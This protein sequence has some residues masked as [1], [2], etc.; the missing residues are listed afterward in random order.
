[1]IR[2]FSIWK[3]N[4]KPLLMDIRDMEDSPSILG[5]YLGVERLADAGFRQLGRIAVL[6]NQER[7]DADD[8]FETTALNRGLQFRFFYADEKEAIAWLTHQKGN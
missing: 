3:Q 4:Q 7:H 6:D 2:V 5:D 1:M 8:F